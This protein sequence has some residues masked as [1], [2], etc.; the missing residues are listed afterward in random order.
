MST[1]FR[2]NNDKD[3]NTETVARG[4]QADFLCLFEQ[5]EIACGL[6]CGGPGVH[7]L[8][9]YASDQF[10]LPRM[11]KDMLD[12]LIS[13]FFYSGKD[14]LYTIGIQVCL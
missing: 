6:V 12:N 11:M 9:K 8:T 4:H 13:T 2:R 10:N 3:V 5:Y 14:D 7:D 1:Q